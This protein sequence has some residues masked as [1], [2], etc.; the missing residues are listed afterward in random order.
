MKLDESRLNG[1]D[2]VISQ[3]A[4]RRRHQH[5]NMAKAS[6]P[7]TLAATV[8]AGVIYVG[9]MFLAGRTDWGNIGLIAFGGA[10]IP[11]I[12]ASLLI[13]GSRKS[14]PVTTAVL[15]TIFASALVIAILSASRVPLSFTGLA[16]TLPTTLIGV[17]IANIAVVGCLKRSVAV[18][19][20]PGAAEVAQRI[21]PH[22][23]VL[24]AA[25][26]DITVQ[27]VLID[28]EAHHTPAWAPVLA[29]LYLRGL[30]IETW[31]AFLEGHS[32]RVEIETFEL[33]DVTYSPSQIFYYRTKRIVDIIAVLIAAIPAAFLGFFVWLYIRIIDGS[34]SI[35]VQERR[36][37][38]GSTF[39]LF[40]FRTMA[41][42]QDVGSTSIDD[43][44][45]LPGCNFI[46]QIR[47]DELPQLLNILRGDM[48]FIGPRPVSVAV[49]ESLEASIP[50]YINRQILQPGLT[51]WAQVSQGYA[52]TEKE[53][54][55]K[56][57]YDLYYLKHVSLDLDIIIIFRTI[58]TI[59][60][61]FGAR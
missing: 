24:F 18:L 29:R 3:G 51:G 36:G 35:F 31:P 17:T 40:K 60:L 25:D 52:E 4:Q 57:S 50:Q 15:V 33:S 44:R 39:R 23:T 5:I 43:P 12:A 46:R 2:A 22:V 59:L 16:A 47:V 8:L 20:F 28:P 56:L 11:A 14:Y 41:N 55:V 21:G 42:G 32:G 26:T 58:K 27:R 10:A 9:V 13:L 37:Y 34:P 6:L 49:A 19:D 53:E 38:G 48:S 61:R 45:I 1:L 30:D 54:L 7:A